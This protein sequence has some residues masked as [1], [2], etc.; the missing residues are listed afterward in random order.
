[1]KSIHA[2]KFIMHTLGPG[3]QIKGSSTRD[4]AVCSPAAQAQGIHHLLPAAPGAGLVSHQGSGVW[5]HHPAPP[6]RGSHSLTSHTAT[7]ARGTSN[8]AGI[9]TASLAQLQSIPACAHPRPESHAQTPIL[10]K[11]SIQVLDE[12]TNTLKSCSSNC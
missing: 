12:Q 3:I 9:S 4:F 7:A 8:A 1:M 11:N 2:D 5:N 6:E 10:I